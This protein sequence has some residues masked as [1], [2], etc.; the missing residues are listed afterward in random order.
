MADAFSYPLLV[1]LE[2]NNIPKLRLK[3]VKYFQGTKS[4]G[5]DC[6]VAHENGSRA[7]LLRF[8]TE[9]DQR[10]V[11]AKE[12]H[13]ITLETGVLRMT[14]RLPPE[15]RAAKS[16]NLHQLT[17]AA[18]GQTDARGTD[19]NA[20]DEELCS[21]SAVL[22]N[23]PEKLS[24]EFL[25]ML[26]E[27]VSVDPESPSAS[28]SFKLEVIPDI[29]SAV[30]T[31]Q[32]RKEITDFVT[33]CPQIRI[34]TSKGLSIRHLEVTKQVAVENIQ[35]LSEALLCLYFEHE[36]VVVENV[37]L[38]EVEQSAIITFKS[39]KAVQKIMKKKHH[40]NQ[41]QIKVY[42]YYESLGT[43]LYGKDRPD[44]QLPA[45][46]SVPI[47]NAVW[48]YLNENQS[49]AD[50]IHSDLAKHFC[51]VN[52]N[53]SAVC[54]SPVSSLLREKGAKAI[55]TEWSGTVKS[56]F[57]QALSKFKSLKFQPM[58]EVWE[59]SE[60]NLRRGLP[61]KD[62]VLVPDKA[63]GVLSVVG[64]VDD[65]NRIE[66]SLTEVINKIVKRVHRQNSS[67]TQVI[68]MSPSIFHLLCEDGLKDKLLHVY[69]E[70][71]MSFNKDSPGLSVTG[72]SEELL[73]ANKVICEAIY[74][75]KRVNLEINKFLLDVLKVEEQEELT[76]TLLT[77]HGIN[78]ALEINAQRV[79]LLAFSNG[80]LTKAEDH[81]KKLLTSN[82]I[83]VEDRNVLG[84]P[85]WQH[86]V[87]QVEDDNSK[88]CRRLRIHTNGQQV[89]VSGHKDDVV[90]VSSELEDFLK[91]NAQVDETLVVKPN[92]IVEYIQKL[93]SSCLERVKDKVGVSYRKET[94]CLNGSRVDVAHC[95]TL[96]EDLIQSVFFES[97]KVYKPGV[98]KF[99]RDKETMYVSSLLSETGCSVQLVDETSYGQDHL[100]HRQGPKPVYQLQTPDG[101]EIA[102]CKA[103]MC[104]YQVHAVVNSSNK[105]LKHN[106]GLA[107][108][109]L[110]AAGA[111]LQV[112]CDQI[113][114]FKGNLKPGDCVIT[115]A[116]G[117]L[118]CKKVIHAV[119]PK[120][121]TSTPQKSLA[122]LKKAVKGSLELAEQHKCVTVAL[123]TIS[124]SKGFP[125]D[126]CSKTI[127]Q[128]VKEHCDERYG[129][130][131][132]K[133]IHLVNNDDTVVQAMEKA[134]RHE[135]GNYV[136]SHS[137]SLG[138]E[139]PLVKHAPSAVSDPNCLG[140]GKTK[141]D[142]DIFLT[143]GNIED[144]TT[145]VTVNT[146]FEDLALNKGAV[147]NAI[148]RVAGPQLQQLVNAQKTSANVGEII[149]TDGCKMKSKQVFHAV[150]LPWDKGQGKAEKVLSGIFKDCLDKAEDTGLTSISL[151]AI[152]TGNL[153]F[154]RDLVANLMLK[155]ISAFSIEK[156]PKHLKKVDIILYSGDAQT[157]QV[158]S[159]EFEKG[160]PDASGGAASSSLP[161]NTGPFSKV[162][163]GLGKHE[164]KMGSVTIQVVTG[165]ITKETSEV[166][167]NSSNEDFSLKSG[168]SKAI[169]D[170]AG[171][172][173]EAEC[174][175]LGAQPNPGMITTQPGNLKCK[176]IVHLAGQTDPV[177]IRKSV[178][179]A[180][181]LCVK[182]SHTSVSLP[183]IGTGQGN[184]QARQVADAMFDAVTDVLSQNTISHLKTIR[185]VIF[186]PPMLKEFYN[187]MHQREQS[188]VPKPNNKGWFWGTIGSLKSLIGSRGAVNPQKGG[189][190]LIKAVEGSPAC[191]HIC[192]DSQP[193]VAA[194]KQWINNLITKDQKTNQIS[195]PAIHNLSVADHQRIVDIQK[196]MG[197]SIRIESKNAQASLTTEGFSK[198]VLDAT[199]EI[200]GM[201]KRVRDEEDLKKSME[202]AGTVADWQYQ[203]PGLRFQSFDPMIN[204]Q[205]E[206]ALDSKL[207]NVKVTLQGHVYT[208]TMPSGPATDSK[209]GTLQ[210]KRIDK[211]TDADVPVHWD[212]MPA[213]TSCQAVTLKPGAAEHTEI[214]NLFQASCNRP[215][216]KIERIQ[217]PLLWK[218]LQIKKRD[219]EQ[220]NGHQNNLRR[221][222]HGT[223]HT[224][225]N[226][227][228]ELGFNRSYAGKNAAVHGNGTYFAVNA[229]YS[230]SDTYSKPNG[231]GEKF[232]YLCQV[233]TGDFTKGQQNMIAPPAKGNVSVQKYDS[234]VDNKDNPS[235]F[236][237]FHDSQACP[238]YLITFK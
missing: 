190:F 24:L 34:F 11:L 208:V 178:K 13:Q 46:I 156:Q 7:A 77:S 8:R 56:A 188:N 173:V 39:N 29:S 68:K 220:R 160:F 111:Q 76:N 51:N 230:A 213:K 114:K 140:H 84:K 79:E 211:L 149:V 185:I 155:E 70:L 2:E 152:G 45:K 116:G 59:E 14:V 27:R 110:N 167:V 236:I 82:Y 118:C 102:V 199:N 224:T 63:S 233:L 129:D 71:S 147:S 228:N 5:G 148:L 166:I 184:V 74:G 65:V 47:D 151:P 66:E 164:T 62:V 108:A 207:P 48:R 169:L 117:Q 64:F 121:D 182:N 105:H 201:L 43:A 72:V 100:A 215:V 113:I 6:V 133:N 12:S 191:F 126:L 145:D 50:T 106:G 195:D 41:E 10:N 128:A 30:V 144:A 132:L 203:N 214:L 221:L 37:V 175:R 183:A 4:N 44:L 18:E 25:E 15:E 87:S 237:I 209:G 101:V 38:K 90:K 3:L 165:D 130:N 49:A 196:T 54:L 103:D 204:Y 193:N 23:I 187:S 235:M 80:D 163:S 150:L 120:Y 53:Q 158:F 174:Q 32:S 194:A 198:D 223:C 210:I 1:E 125:L 73:A 88:S 85:D 91:Q 137:S 153:G 35:N 109:L 172:S 52:L 55:I 136:A 92:A 17:P 138:P 75:F 218:S 154:P 141:E 112:D 146:V 162:V 197:V 234:V 222:F 115:D 104:S 229:N 81:L 119:G 200:H 226:M 60:E 189:D 217:N 36:G 28:Q 95:K 159:D 202:L 42:P 16:L 61:I 67:I 186:Q 86:L 9:E 99:F 20:A 176:K 97:F 127:I 33:R 168:V 181:Q 238:E 206:Q 139:S 93:N 216:I 142:L 83:D 161:Q 135:F 107:R 157:I 98:K 180:L 205:L 58:S 179:D 22:G 31:F 21:T 89:V 96:V 212:P 122:Q 69:P 123:P 192:G 57:A 231:N 219:M 227:I 26:V 131:T 170:A 177:K 94:I 171:Q 78:A 143:K 232:M 134:V 40:I 124:S 225:V 19:D